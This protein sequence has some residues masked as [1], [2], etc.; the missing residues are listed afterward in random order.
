MSSLKLVQG[1][2]FL[3]VMVRAYRH[4]L[5]DNTLFEF[6]EYSKLPKVYRSV[7]DWRIKHDPKRSCFGCGER[8]TI[9]DD[10]GSERWSM[11]W[12]TECHDEIRRNIEGIENDISDW[13][14]DK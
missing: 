6:T 5:T 8:A 2:F 10:T 14:T 4:F 3:P 7:K 9:F 12:C 11:D 1:Q 13:A